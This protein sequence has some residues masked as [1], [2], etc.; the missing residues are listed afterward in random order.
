MFD[1]FRYKKDKIHVKEIL[2]DL[3]LLLRVINMDSFDL[4]KLDLFPMDLIVENVLE[5]TSKF[6][7]TSGLFTIKHW[8]R[9][10]NE[11]KTYVVNG[12]MKVNAKITRK[13]SP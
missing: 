12:V 4:L 13:P 9:D 8:I 7:G 2:E 3:L 5:S 1:Y 6:V 10:T 11:S